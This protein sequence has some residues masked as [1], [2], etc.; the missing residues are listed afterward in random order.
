MKITDQLKIGDYIY[1]EGY[2]GKLLRKVVWKN[3]YYF[4]W[5]CGWASVEELK[6]NK[7][8]TSKVKFILNN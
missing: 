7:N 3:E 5:S 4:E 1:V 6:I 2:Y 8:K